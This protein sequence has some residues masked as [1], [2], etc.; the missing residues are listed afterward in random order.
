MDRLT[1]RKKKKLEKEVMSSL[2]F[3]R[4]TYEFCSKKLVARNETYKGRA[5]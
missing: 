1:S 5:K 3:P 2:N 4:N